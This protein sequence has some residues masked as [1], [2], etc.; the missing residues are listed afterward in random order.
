[1]PRKD[2]PQPPRPPEFGRSFDPARYQLV[3][4]ALLSALIVAA[5][6][7]AFGIATGHAVDRGAVVAL[8]V[9]YPE[10]WRSKDVHTIEV[11]VTNTSARDLSRIDV[12]FDRR[13]FHAYAATS[14]EPNISSVTDEAY[15]VVVHDVRPDE[16]RLVTTEVRADRYGVQDGFVTASTMDGSARVRLRSFVFP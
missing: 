12:A 1:M 14:F 15:L 2:G 3:G 5:V 7:G 4:I 16:T 8:V 13:Y 11:E 10:R 9:A 6:A